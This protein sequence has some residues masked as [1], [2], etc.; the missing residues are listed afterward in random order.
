MAWYVIVYEQGQD[1]L[2]LQEHLKMRGDNLSRKWIFPK[3]RG[4]HEC[5]P[6]VSEPVLVSGT[7]PTGALTQM[8]GNTI[9]RLQTRNAG[10]V[11]KRLRNGSITSRS[12]LNYVREFLLYTCQHGYK[13]IA[14]PKRTAVER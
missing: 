10:I 13:Y 3:L 14:L 7:G 5:S 8:R 9:S 6:G 12:F 2:Y 11:M 4:F 1:G